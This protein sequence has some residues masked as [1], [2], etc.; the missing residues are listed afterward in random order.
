MTVYADVLFIT[1]FIVD[2][3]LIKLTAKITHT[4]Y[5][6]VR[7]LLASF[8]GGI[9]A[10]Y[11]FVPNV[12]TVLDILIK[13]LIAFAVTFI[14]FDFKGIKP[15]LRNTAVFFAVS[16]GFAGGMLAIWHIAKPNGMVINNSVVYFNISPILLIAFS[17]ATYFITALIRHFLS[18]NQ[19]DKD[20]VKIQF[21]LKESMTEGKALID[22]GNSLCDAFGMSEIIITDKKISD[23]LLK[24]E[25]ESEKKKRYRAIPCN[26]VSGSEIL[27]GFR[28]DKAIII[29]NGNKN[30]IVRPII[31]ISKTKISNEID[32]IINP[33][34]V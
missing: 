14:T 4:N 11:I 28:I 16:F 15:F 13:L 10:L 31:A 26:T 34:S 12:N 25:S 27:D 17:V 23:F 5:K 24:N 30:E 21:F 2:Y 7:I 18:K 3:F 19:A 20:I 6:T 9:T 29:E 8:F 22:S 33:R 1:N 32:A